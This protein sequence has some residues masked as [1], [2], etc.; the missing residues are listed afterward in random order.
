M[1]NFTKLLAAALLVVGVA[2]CGEDGGNGALKDATDSMKDAAGDM[3]DAASDMTK[4]AA[5]KA[6]DAAGSMADSA[7]SA[8]DSAKDAAG[9]AAAGVGELADLRHAINTDAHLPIPGVVHRNPGQ[10]RE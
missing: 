4:A 7:R 9:D 10:L 3:K 8:V 1:T 6:S 5:D 2:A